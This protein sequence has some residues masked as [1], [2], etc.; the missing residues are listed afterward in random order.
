MKTLILAKVF[1]SNS[2]LKLTRIA[3]N[4]KKL[5]SEK[6]ECT[7]LTYKKLKVIEICT[8]RNNN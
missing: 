4:R 6:Q 7:E 1:N 2:R 8:R 3:T 5:G